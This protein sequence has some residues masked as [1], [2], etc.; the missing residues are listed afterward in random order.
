MMHTFAP[1]AALIYVEVA[2]SGGLLLHDQAQA[3]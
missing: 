1:G 3:P 2:N